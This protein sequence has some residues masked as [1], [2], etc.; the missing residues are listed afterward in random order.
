M[1]ARGT[2]DMSG[3]GVWWAFAVLQWAYDHGCPWN[4]TSICRNAAAAGGHL[5]MLKW[6]HEHGCPWDASTCRDAAAGGYLGCCSGRESM[7]AP[8]P[9]HQVAAFGGHLEVLQW[10]HEH[11][12]P[13]NAS[14]SRNAAYCGHLEVLQWVREHGCPW[15]ASTCRNAA[16]GGHLEVLQW[17]R[18]HGCPW[19]ASTC[20]VAAHGG[21]LEVLQWAREHG[22]P[23]WDANTYYV[24]SGCNRGN[25][26]SA[27]G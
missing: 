2:Q 25:W 19:D 23:G 21:H 11:G 8:W 20:Q 22:C 12:C 5:E 6:A 15:D 24:D 9:Q 18:E 26:S 4:A 1:A 27:N 13:W 7:A 17:A 3:C 10:A 14:T 16:A